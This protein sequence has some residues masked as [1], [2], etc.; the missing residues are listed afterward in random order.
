MYPC[1]GIL[2]LNRNGKKWLSPLYDSLREDG[3]PNKRVYLVDN[4]S[5]DGTHE[6]ALEYARRD[7]RIR[8]HRN[9]ANLY[10]TIV[11]VAAD[12]KLVRRPPSASMVNDWVR[13]AAGLGRT[14]EY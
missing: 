6:L 1:F 11:K 14:I 3:Y 12:R 4:A 8:A 10:Q 9:P 7:P 13:E 5:D 2:V